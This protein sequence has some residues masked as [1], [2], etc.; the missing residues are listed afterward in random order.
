M[1]NLKDKMV[2]QERDSTGGAGAIGLD[3]E[4]VNGNI[5][6]NG[7]VGQSEM[8]CT[9]NGN[10]AGSSRESFRTYKRRKR[11]QAVEDVRSSGDLAGQIK[12]KVHWHLI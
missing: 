7:F 11:A 1:I 5:K 6:K 10:H 12:E 8:G 3:G 9:A 2:D 4:A